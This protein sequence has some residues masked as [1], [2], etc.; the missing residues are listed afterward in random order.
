[1]TIAIIYVFFLSRELKDKQELLVSELAECIAEA[2]DKGQGCISRTPTRDV[3]ECGVVKVAD[4]MQRQLCDGLGKHSNTS[5]NGNL[6][7]CRA[8]VDTLS[9]SASA[10]EVG[11]A[12]AVVAVLRLVP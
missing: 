12:G 8:V 1:M 7:H 4:H 9:G 6:L 11:V 5:V 3:A 2:S 10:E